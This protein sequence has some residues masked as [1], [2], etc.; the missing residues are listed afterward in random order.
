MDFGNA[1]LSDLVLEGARTAVL[2]LF[3]SMFICKIVSYSN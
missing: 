2:T 3:L 1:L